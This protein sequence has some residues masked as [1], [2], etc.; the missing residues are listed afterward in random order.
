M[1]RTVI[2]SSERLLQE[3][4]GWVEHETPSPDAAAV[5]GLLDLAE[6]ELR[7]VGAAIERLPGQGGFGDTLIARKPGEGSPVVVAGHLDTVWDHG[8]LAG[9]M[10]FRVEGD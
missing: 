10:P 2:G 7:G 3:L 9:P 8:T 5:N 4:R 6:R 1:P